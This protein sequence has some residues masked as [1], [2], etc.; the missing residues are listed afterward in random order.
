MRRFVNGL[1][2]G[3]VIKLGKGKQVPEPKDDAD[4]AVS[5]E[6]EILDEVHNLMSEKDITFIEALRRV[7]PKHA[8]SGDE[9]EDD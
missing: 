6:K 9:E 2:K 5:G 1:P 3:C 8:Q 7:S 4:L